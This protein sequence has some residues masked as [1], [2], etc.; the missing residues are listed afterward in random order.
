[1]QSFIARGE[2]NENYNKRRTVE[3]YLM[4]NGERR[5]ASKIVD[6]SRSESWEVYTHRYQYHALHNVT[7]MVGKAT[8]ILNNVDRFLSLWPTVYYVHGVGGKGTHARN[9]ASRKASRSN[10]KQSQSKQLRV[11]RCKEEVQKVQNYAAATLFRATNTYPF[12][13]SNRP[14]RLAG[15]GTLAVDCPMLAGRDRSWRWPL[16]PRWCCPLSL[17]GN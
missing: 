2:N 10:R 3:S 4:Y 17:S 6:P 16:P 9:Q 7:E 11:V 15:R 13:A 1:M 12:P 14:W 5:E 8:D